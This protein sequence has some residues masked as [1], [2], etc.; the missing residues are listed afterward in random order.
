MHAVDAAT[1]LTWGVILW[2]KATEETFWCPQTFIVRILIIRYKCN[3]GF[4]SG[5]ERRGNRHVAVENERERAWVCVLCE[6]MRLASI[7]K[8]TLGIV[9]VWTTFYN[10]VYLNCEK[11][12]RKE[13]GRKIIKIMALFTN[14]RGTLGDIKW[15]DY[16]SHT[17][18]TVNYG[19]NFS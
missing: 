12:E 13:V 15:C 17:F 6:K 4:Y 16:I 7:E 5:T 10:F 19:W 9:S 8:R 11:G 18:S 3:N 14:D 1:Y 2:N